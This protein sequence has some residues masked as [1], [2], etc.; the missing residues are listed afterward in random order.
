MVEPLARACTHP[1]GPGLARRPVAPAADPGLG[2]DVARGDPGPGRPRRPY[3]LMERLLTPL[4]VTHADAAKALAEQRLLRARLAEVP[5]LLAG[6]TDPEGLALQGW[7]SFLQGDYARVIASV[8]AA[9]QAIRKQTRKRNVYTPGIPGALYLLALLRRGE[10]ADFERVQRQ[11]SLCLR[12]SVSDPIERAYRLLGDLAAVLAGQ[13]RVA[14]CGWLRDSL[15]LAGRLSNPVPGPGPA[16]A[17]RAPAGR[18]APRRWRPAPAKRPW[19]DWIGMPRRPWPCSRPSAS[20]AS[21]PTLGAAA[22]RPGPDDRA[23]G[24]QA[25]LGAGPGCPQ[26]ARRPGRR[27]RAPLPNPRR[28]RTG[29]WPGN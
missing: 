12:A 23:A 15:T 5:P 11:V 20:K 22:R 10:R 16:L 6:Q 13:R 17:R 3:E 19:P 18:P 24:P 28:A 1:T 7:L 4:A 25:G 29:A 27:G 21:L 9:E 8:E 26:G 14:E 2:P